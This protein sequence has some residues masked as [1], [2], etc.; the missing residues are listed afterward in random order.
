MARADSSITSTKQPRRATFKPFSW[1]HRGNQK[2][3][4][5]Q[6]L[7]LTLDITQG[8]ETALELI[9]ANNFLR[10]ACDDHEPT[11]LTDSDAE[12]LMRFSITSA[13]LLSAAVFDRI[14]LINDIAEKNTGGDHD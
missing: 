6:F 7:A 3:I 11:L 1:L 8:I 10:E 13:G 4:N 9:H 14:E 12:R 2:D 5:A